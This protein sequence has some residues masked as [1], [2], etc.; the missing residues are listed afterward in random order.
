[1]TCGTT[2]IVQRYQFT[3]GSNLA[4]LAAQERR[5]LATFLLT[6]FADLW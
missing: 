4:A 5:N 1:M 2:A 3:I 6:A